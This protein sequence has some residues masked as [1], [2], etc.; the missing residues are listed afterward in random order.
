MWDAEDFEPDLEYYE[1]QN[2]LCELKKV[3]F[4]CLIEDLLERKAK[5]V[6][7]DIYVTTKKKYTKAQLIELLPEMLDDI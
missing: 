4:R 1:H 5:E 7:A 2:R 6:C 3:L